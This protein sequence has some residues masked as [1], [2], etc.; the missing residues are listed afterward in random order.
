MRKQTIDRKQKQKRGG[1]KR[2]R[3]ERERERERGEERRCLTVQYIF[4]FDG[5]E[6][7]NICAI[8]CVFPRFLKIEY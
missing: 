1:K 5:R 7:H 3:E 8:T 4:D 2:E 6:T